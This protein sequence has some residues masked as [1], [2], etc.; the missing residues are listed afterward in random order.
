ME[1][2]KGMVGEATQIPPTFSQFSLKCIN[3][4]CFH[5]NMES[6]TGSRDATKIPQI[7]S[8]FSFKSINLFIFS[9]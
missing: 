1:N 8:Q 4:L 7:F 9:W 2:L 5:D 3:F 6:G